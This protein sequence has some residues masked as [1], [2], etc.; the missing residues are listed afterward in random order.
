MKLSM[1]E[2]LS[3]YARLEDFA[4][5]WVSWEKRKLVP[6]FISF[7]KQDV[8]CAGKLC[9]LDGINSIWLNV[10]YS[11]MVKKMLHK[12]VNLNPHD[13]PPC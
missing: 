7:C 10:N 6:V 11:A 9:C 13:D 4:T 12:Q 3:L 1:Y 8:E 5:T 2:D